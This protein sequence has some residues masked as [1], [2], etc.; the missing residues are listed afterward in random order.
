MPLLRNPNFTGRDAL[1]DEL[2]RNL[3]DGRVALTAVRGMGG[4]GK[5][6]LALEYA[7]RHAHDFD[8]VWWLRAE[9]PAT[10]L[11]DYA[12]LAEPLGLG[13]SGEGDLVA[14]ADAVCQGLARRNRW[15]L[16]FDNATKP[17]DLISLLPR[18]GVGRVLITSRNPSWPFAVPLDV[19]VLGRDEA[20]GFLLEQTGEQDRI[21]ADAVA[22]ELGDLPLG[23]AQA[24]AYINETG[25]GLA[26]YLDLFRTRRSELWA[27]EKPPVGYPAT[28]GTTMAI[29]RLRARESLALDLLSLCAFLAPEAIP[30]RLLAEHHPALPAELG[31][32]V[33]EPLH[34]NRLVAALRR[35]SLVDTT[36]EALSFHRL[37]QASARDALGPEERRR[38]IEA[39]V[40]LMRAGFPYDPDDPATWA[41]SGA[42]LSHA[43]AAAGHA[44]E[45]AK[46]LEDTRWLLHATARYLQ[47][48][49][50]FERSR[51]GYMRAARLAEAVL[52]P[53]D[54]E[55]AT[56]LN[57]LGRVLQEMRY[58]A[59]A[60]AAYE[61]ALAIDEK[62]FGPDHQNVARDIGNLGSVLLDL[63]LDHL[64]DAR[65]ALERALKIN[66]KSFGPDHPTVAR[67]VNNLGR[68][69]R[70]L[71]DLPGARAA[72]ERALTIYERS[73][74]P[75]HPDTAKVVNNLGRVLRD[76]GD[77]RGARA[78]FEL[79]LAIDEKSFGLVHP[80]VAI[81]LKNLGRVLRELGDWDR[82]RATFER[83]LRIF[84]KHLGPENPNV[85]TVTNY[86]G[87]V[88]QDQGDVTGARAAFER[89]LQIDESS[90]PS[91][92]PNIARDFNNLGG[93]LKEL[94]DLTGAR[95]AYERALAIRERALGPD[96]PKTRVARDNL[97]C[98]GGG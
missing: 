75:D 49:A 13:K 32:A 57:D 23:L 82:A 53:D 76:L 90:L 42:V 79:A 89:A 6:Q 72:F 84:E 16:V 98:L 26:D 86:L 3:R 30:R 71:G 18:G 60:R 4:V 45:N 9:E 44:D 22:N 52:G 85:A 81:R 38:W 50:E 63:G 19:P 29:D 24:A 88:L 25:V 61:Q 7:Y 11:E 10:L 68:V 77:L 94:G 91:D 92:H 33:A 70:E 15:L 87:L 27:E 46:D 54:P 1:L 62:S 47:T 67:N 34:L 17:D 14:V 83:A 64:A 66:E 65:A 20:I 39:A 41:P 48:R 28:V 93:M 80:N 12:A 21:A 31:A 55:L 59:G 74:S 56:Y 36:G 2:N 96:H 8:L 35:Y 43:L 40:A 5:T 51:A 37:V 97:D 95:A 58:V 78:A 69:L 73:F